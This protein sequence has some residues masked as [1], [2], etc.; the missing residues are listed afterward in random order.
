MIIKCYN[1]YIL[2]DSLNI[3]FLICKI[4]LQN[5]LKLYVGI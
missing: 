2:M 3:L 5:Y 1:K 4:E